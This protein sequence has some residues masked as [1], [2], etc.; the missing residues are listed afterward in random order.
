MI[1]QR[2]R[3]GLKRAVEGGKQLGR[4]KISPPPW[5]SVYKLNCEP[6]RACWPLPGTSRSGPARCSALNGK[7]SRPALS[8]A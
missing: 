8:T 2:V 4:P 1:R 6:K 5:E 3:A 7:W